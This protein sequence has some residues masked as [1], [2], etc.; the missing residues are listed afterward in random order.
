MNI[1][2]LVI[3]LAAWSIWGCTPSDS[4]SDAILESRFAGSSAQ[5]CAPLS[6][7]SIRGDTD[8]LLIQVEEDDGSWRTV[9]RF[10]GPFQGATDYPATS[11]V[12]DASA[13]RVI[14]CGQAGEQWAAVGRQSGI[15]RD[16]LLFAPVGDLACLDSAQLNGGASQNRWLNASAFSTSAAAEPGSLIV[17][18]AATFD[19]STNELRPAQPALIHRFDWPSHTFSSDAADVTRPFPIGAAM[20]PLGVEPEAE[21]LIVGG[22]TRL[23]RD[24]S[25]Q[26]GPFVPETGSDRQPSCVGA[27]EAVQR[28]SL[29]G[30]VSPQALDGGAPT[31]RAMAGVAHDR[32][33]TVI[34]SGLECRPDGVAPSRS[35]EIIQG[36]SRRHLELPVRLLGARV[37]PTGDG[38]FLIWGYSDETCGQDPGWLLDPSGPGRLT[39]LALNQPIPNACIGLDGCPNWYPSAYSTVTTIGTGRFLIT[40]GL[41]GGD[42]GVS[43]NPAI[44]SE[45]GGNVFMLVINQSQGQIMPIE[46]RPGVPSFQRAFHVASRHG[47][48]VLLSGGWTATANGGAVS[49]PGA[50]YASRD[51]FT[52]DIPRR[53]FQPGGLMATP[54]WGHLHLSTTDDQVLIA[55][56]AKATPEG[57][58]AFEFND[59]VELWTS[60][61]EDG[62]C[63]TD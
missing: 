38:R 44:R 19:S 6:P 41:P 24:P 52:F 48:T 35:V 43:A 20:V 14:L 21:I 34:A 49:N 54:R 27:E 7:S 23:R 62:T 50:L 51:W 45:C 61:L 42:S 30:R 33:I 25:G 11:D 12:V 17:G 53:S 31:T 3:A 59:V 18:G 26:M 8:Q 60:P 39:P 55:G 40:G 15:T 2:T 32:G 10:Q 29:A 36:L 47:D 16:D 57:Q 22:A 63:Q 46:R 56:G 9:D 4:R 1:P 13:L 28:V 5:N 58:D 37:A